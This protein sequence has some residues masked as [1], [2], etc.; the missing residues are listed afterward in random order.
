MERCGA[1]LIPVAQEDYMLMERECF[2]F[3]LGKIVLDNQG[4]GDL[5]EI[6]DLFCLVYKREQCSRCN[7]FDDCIDFIFDIL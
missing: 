1:V 3:G 7:Q 6:A 5:W 4:N 2:G